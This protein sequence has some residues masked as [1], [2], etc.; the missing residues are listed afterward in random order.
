M[1]AKSE[2]AVLRCAVC[3]AP[4]G[5]KCGGCGEVAYCGKEHQRQHWK[6]HKQQCRH[7]RQAA[8]PGALTQ[9][10]DLMQGLHSTLN[11]REDLAAVVALL[12]GDEQGGSTEDRAEAKFVLGI[13]HLLLED[14]E[15]AVLN[16]LM[17]RVRVR[18]SVRVKDGDAVPT[19]CNRLALTPLTSA[20]ILPAT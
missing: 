4:G 3:A 19:R 9:A 8:K 1:A 7:D 16:L 18:V 13:T 15:P 2:T 11:V 10:V 6:L 5:Q 17:V 20:V 12:S 14:M